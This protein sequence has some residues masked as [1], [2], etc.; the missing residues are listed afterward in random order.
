[1]VRVD[2]PDLTLLRGADYPGMI[3]MAP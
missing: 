3:L 2:E 1:L